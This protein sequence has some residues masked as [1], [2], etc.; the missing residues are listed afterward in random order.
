MTVFEAESRCDF[1]LVQRQDFCGDES[2]IKT[3]SQYEY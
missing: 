2:A 1:V 3:V